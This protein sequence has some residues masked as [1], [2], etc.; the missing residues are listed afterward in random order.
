MLELENM[1]VKER[2]KLASLR[3]KHYQLAGASEGWEEEVSIFKIFRLQEE[4][5][6]LNNQLQILNTYYLHILLTSKYV[7]QLICTN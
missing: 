4:K 1:L 5:Y 3:K 2:V 6:L 7:T